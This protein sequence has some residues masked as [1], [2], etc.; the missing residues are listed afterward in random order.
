VCIA[1]PEENHSRKHIF[2]IAMLCVQRGRI[3]SCEGGGG[4][5]RHYMG[6]L[7]N[8]SVDYADGLDSRPSSEST[9]FLRR[10]EDSSAVGLYR[11]DVHLNAVSWR[12]ALS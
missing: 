7:D 12:F 5:E 10:R 4:Q 9:N 3:H 8:L 11:D 1:S 6:S 2:Y